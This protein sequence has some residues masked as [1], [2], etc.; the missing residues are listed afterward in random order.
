MMT[1]DPVVL[2]VRPELDILL[3]PGD[4]LFIPKRPSSVTVSGEVLNPGSFQFRSGATVQDYLEFSGGAKD[5]A[6]ESRTFVV[7]PDGSAAP[8]ALNW[9]SF[10][11]SDIPPGSTIVV[12]R[13]LHPFD[14]TSFLKDITQITS[15]LAIT[16]ASLS[17]LGKN[18]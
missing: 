5:D 7:L 17:V 11:H 14:W 3:E 4:K 12:P 16:A 15:Q 1:A 2:A 8:V 13:D 18:N 6:D 10:D 9:L